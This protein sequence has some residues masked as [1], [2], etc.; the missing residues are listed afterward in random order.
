M[1][2]I[3]IC[4]K[5]GLFLQLGTFKEMPAK[6]DT[7]FIVR[8]VQVELI[9]ALHFSMDCLNPAD[10]FSHHASPLEVC[11]GAFGTVGVFSVPAWMSYQTYRSVRYR[12]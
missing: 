1:I 3:M 6:G 5:C 9:H 10:L 8:L 4:P 12:Y 11:K 7:W 2:W